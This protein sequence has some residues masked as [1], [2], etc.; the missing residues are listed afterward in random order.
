MRNSELIILL[1]FGCFLAGA[2]YHIFSMLE[3]KR[4]GQ[5]LNWDRLLF[6]FFSNL[7]LVC[8]L[9][10]WIFE[11]L[12][13]LVVSSNLC[14][15]LVNGVGFGLTYSFSREKRKSSRKEIA[16]TGLRAYKIYYQGR[17]YGLITKEGFDQLMHFKLLK[18]QRTV[19]LIEN[20]QQQARVQGVE[21]VCYKNPDRSQTL[22]KVEVLQH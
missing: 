19:E 1:L 18:K 21:V 17:S 3:R 11:M 15:V 5:S 20:Y 4:G 22:I 8:L 9:P 2:I 12:S 7:M 13:S 14:V 16:S 6:L 10:L